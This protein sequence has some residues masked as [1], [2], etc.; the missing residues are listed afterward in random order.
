MGATGV[1]IIG[2][3]ADAAKLELVGI[4]YAHGARIVLVGLSFIDLLVDIEGLVVG[5]DGDLPDVRFC[6][7]GRELEH[8]S[9]VG[10]PLGVPASSGFLGPC[11]PEVSDRLIL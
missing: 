6:A 5:E 7:S 9:I 11:C 2:F 10:K 8:F 4:V 3:G 1:V